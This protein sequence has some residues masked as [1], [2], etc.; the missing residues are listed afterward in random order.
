MMDNAT[1]ELMRAVEALTEANRKLYALAYTDSLTGIHNRRY[2]EERTQGRGGFFVV[3]D[4]NGFKQAQDAHPEG[5][6]YGD[7]VLVEFAEFLL[8]S[9]RQGTDRIAARM[10]GDEFVVWCPSLEGAQ[11]IYRLVQQWSSDDARVSAS[12]GVGSTM[13]EADASLYLC[14]KRR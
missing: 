14:K 7:R 6:R 12:A 4:L 3:A 10:G 1:S 8:Q 11:R 5:H 13:T 9:T 2:I